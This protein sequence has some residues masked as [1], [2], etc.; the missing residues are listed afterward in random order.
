M[1]QL[2]AFDGVGG[3][4]VVRDAAFA[5]TGKLSTP[6]DG[7]LAPLRSERYLAE[8]NAC[9]RL[10][11]VITTPSLAERLDGRL[12]VAVADE[13]DAAHA[14]VHARLA[15]VREAELAARP[16]EI[17]PTARID[18]SAT[19]ASHGVTIEAGVWIGPG[20]VV[21]PGSVLEAEVA[22]HACAIIGV[23]GFQ[24]VRIGGR[25]RIAPQLGGVRLKQGVELLAHVTVARASF[26]GETEIGEET[27]AD[28]HVYIAHDCRIGRR[29]QLCAH[30]N[31]MG[32]VEIGEEAYIG[33]SAVIVNGARIGARAKVTM[34][35][36]VTRDVAPDA[37]V[38][39]NFAIDHARFL[40]HLRAIRGGPSA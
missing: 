3:L 24:A 8:A 34:G 23:A 40:D 26:G 7:L 10:A 35:A 2:S 14:E 9:A 30:A 29:V 15:A 6:L 12:G 37:V 1:Q 16:T 25:Q 18:D 17:H 11:A 36:V 22:L 31:V 38:S 13:P 28:C 21:A 20:C 33:P 19:I 27:L 4:K 32:R 5:V 39:G